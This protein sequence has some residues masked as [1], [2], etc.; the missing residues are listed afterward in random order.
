MV[1]GQRSTANDNRFEILTAGVRVPSVDASPPLSASV[2]FHVVSGAPS[3]FPAPVAVRFHA[4]SAHVRANARCRPGIQ[5]NT[6]NVQ[7]SIILWGTGSSMVGSSPV[8]DWRL[9]TSNNAFPKDPHPPLYVY[10][11]LR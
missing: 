2:L 10:S 7:F 4:S 1:T 3:L 9:T 6:I 8:P 5:M 11:Q